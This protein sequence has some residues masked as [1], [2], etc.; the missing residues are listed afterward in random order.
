VPEYYMKDHPLFGEDLVDL[1]IN[2]CL[3][4]FIPDILMD[5]LNE[6]GNA[7]GTRAEFCIFKIP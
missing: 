1:F 2:E 3:D 7:V 6:I 4:E 5:A